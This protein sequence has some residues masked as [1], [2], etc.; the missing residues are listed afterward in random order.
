MS[1][2]PHQADAQVTLAHVPR[3][4]QPYTSDGDLAVR[5]VSPAAIPELGA[6]LQD[7]AEPARQDGDPGDRASGDMGHPGGRC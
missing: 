4:Q 1:H 5:P 7:T 2:A 3:E 6:P